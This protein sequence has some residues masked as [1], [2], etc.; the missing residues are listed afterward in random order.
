M[1]TASRAFAPFHVRDRAFFLAMAG[2]AWVAILAGFGPELYGQARGGS[3]FPSAIVL[4]HGAAFFG[5]LGLFTAQ[6]WLI[7]SKRVALH[8][9]L[10]VAGAIMVPLMVLLG[11]EAN[12][13]AQRAHFAAGESQ[14]NFM[15]VPITDMINFASLAGAGLLL[16]KRSAAHKRLLLLATICILDAGF[17]RIVRRLVAGARRGRL[18]RVHDADVP[19]L[20]SRDRRGHGL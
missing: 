4:V 5:W 18:L 13:V 7:R 3:P 11:L 2:I 17:G 6:V 19:V 12:V 8:R 9:K 14:L 10:G 16:R 1:Q 15:I 20:R